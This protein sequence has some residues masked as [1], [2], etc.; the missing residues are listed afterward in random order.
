M[1]MEDNNLAVDESRRI[2]QHEAVKDRV[3]GEVGAEVAARA[4]RTTPVDDTR[5]AAVA[6]TFKD[7][8]Y[9]EVV[10]TE[11]ELETTKG[12]ARASQIID[13]VFYLIYGIIGLEIILEMLGARD[14]ATFKQ[15]VDTIAAPFL[16]PF[17]GLMPTPS[18]GPFRLMLSYIVA[19]I[20]YLLLHLAVNG[21]LRL[22]A[23]RKVAV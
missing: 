18:A 2:M 14:S 13:Y 15:F 16:A 3:A 4:D 20:A 23:H 5:A 12:V 17:Q 21:F 19:L 10:E 9:R 7:K 11:A 8:A 22:L 1:A 6:D